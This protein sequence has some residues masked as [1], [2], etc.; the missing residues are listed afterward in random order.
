MA[1]FSTVTV[2]FRGGNSPS[3]CSAS[4][5]DASSINGTKSTGRQA[6]GLGHIFG[7]RM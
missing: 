1:T 5:G 4:A 7:G 3:T 6:L 2:P